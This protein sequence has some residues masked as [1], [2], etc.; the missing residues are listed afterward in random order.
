MRP[1]TDA[2]MLSASVLSSGRLFLH[3][4]GASEMTSV[5]ASARKPD[6]MSTSV[7]RSA[8][9]EKRWSHTLAPLANSQVRVHIR[10]I[11]QID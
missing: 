3:F 8:F 5:Q 10:S 6:L 4:F 11:P 1:I 2:E 9:F 7:K